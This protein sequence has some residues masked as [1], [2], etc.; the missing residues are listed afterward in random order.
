MGFCE[1][2]VADAVMARGGAN[3]GTAMKVRDFT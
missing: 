1:I 2:V 3:H